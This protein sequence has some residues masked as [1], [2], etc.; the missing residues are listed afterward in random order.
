MFSLK[1][2]HA[3]RGDFIGST[4]Y[5]DNLEAIE[6]AKYLC[7]MYQDITAIVTEID[8]DEQ[9]YIYEICVWNESYSEDK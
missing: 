2:Y 1:K 7:E 9:G 3:Q 4:M 5:L 8:H 6:K